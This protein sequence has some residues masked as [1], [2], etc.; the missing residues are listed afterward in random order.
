MAEQ[1]GLDRDVAEQ[2]DQIVGRISVLVEQS[3][4]NDFERAKQLLETIK[5]GDRNDLGYSMVCVLHFLLAV[6]SD[7]PHQDIRVRAAKAGLQMWDGL[8]DGRLVLQDD[9][10]WEE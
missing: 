9:R 7:C 2:I 8:E 4:Q 5:A 10:C 1:G 3:A 6:A